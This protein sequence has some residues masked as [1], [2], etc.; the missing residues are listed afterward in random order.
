MEAH[1][2]SLIINLRVRADLSL[3]VCFVLKTNAPMKN[4][5]SKLSSQVLY[6]GRFASFICA[7][8]RTSLYLS[9]SGTLCTASGS[10]MQNLA[11]VGK[12]SEFDIHE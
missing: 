6:H 4:T 1:T 9:F 5:K 7:S 11:A 3:N 8:S 2:I 10:V 12:P